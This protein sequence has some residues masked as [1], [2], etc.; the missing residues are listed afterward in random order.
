MFMD[1]SS[2]MIHSVLPLVLVG[3][4]GASVAL[5]GLI[6]GIAKA[7]AAIAPVFSG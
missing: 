6:D 7:T 5:L 4:L 3:T 2:E 1:I